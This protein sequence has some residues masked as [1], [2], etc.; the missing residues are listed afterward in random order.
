MTNPTIGY[1]PAIASSSRRLTRL[2][3]TYY[4]SRWIWEEGEPV[5]VVEIRITGVWTVLKRR[6]TGDDARHEM[7][8]P[9]LDGHFRFQCFRR[10][11]GTGF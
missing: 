8:G 6:A 3:L 5:N 9:A 7:D 11:W 1:S 10:R 2:L 4:A